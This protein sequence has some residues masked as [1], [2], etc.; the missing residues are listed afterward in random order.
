M[1]FEIIFFWVLWKLN[2][3]TWCFALNIVATI[4]SVSTVFSK[5]YNFGKDNANR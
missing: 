4:F 2:A 3:P 1:F 5:V